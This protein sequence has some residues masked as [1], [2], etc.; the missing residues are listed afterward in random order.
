MGFLVFVRTFLKMVNSVYASANLSEGGI[1]CSMRENPSPAKIVVP[2]SKCP[3]YTSFLQM[4][5]QKV[6]EK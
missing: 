2:K 1:F 6:V 3:G 4:N 5:P